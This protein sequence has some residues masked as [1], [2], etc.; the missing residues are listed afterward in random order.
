M[1]A[2]TIFLQLSILKPFQE[3][4]FAVVHPALALL[5][6]SMAAVTLQMHS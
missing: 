3:C 4:I 2:A 5:S 1:A 6:P